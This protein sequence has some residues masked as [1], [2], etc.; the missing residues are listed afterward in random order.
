MNN[1]NNLKHGAMFGLDARIALAIFGALSVISG[2][3]LF[4]AIQK[5]KVTQTIAQ[6]KEVEKA[7]SQQYLDTGSHMDL[8]GPHKFEIDDL[9]VDNSKAGW[10]GPYLSFEYE[11]PSKFFYLNSYGTVSLW[12]NESWGLNSTVAPG[13]DIYCDAGEACSVWIGLYSVKKEI[14][15]AIDKEVDGVSDPV[16][17]AIRLYEDGVNYHL[18]LKTGIPYK[19]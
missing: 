2:A 19:V 1:K 15:E 7:V 14:A 6:M 16:S 13:E 9:F 10:A 5:S 17:G 11:V 18:W 4:S 3:S 8:A 12:A